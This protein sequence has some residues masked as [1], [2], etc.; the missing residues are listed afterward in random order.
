MSTESA[1]IYSLHDARK[2]VSYRT[3]RVHRLAPALTTPVFLPLGLRDATSCAP[4]ANSLLTG[5]TQS[6]SVNL[7]TASYRQCM[8]S[9]NV[10]APQCSHFFLLF[11]S[12][13]TVKQNILGTR[14]HSNQAFESEHW[15]N[16]LPRD[17]QASRWY[18]IATALLEGCANNHHSCLFNSLLDSLLLIIHFRNNSNGVRNNHCVATISLAAFPLLVMTRTICDE[19]RVRDIAQ[20]SSS[21]PRLQE[22]NKTWRIVKFLP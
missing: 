17:A 12:Q 3:H 19:F 18:C 8:Q 1:A 4:T 10:V 2:I 21:V 7:H 6:M 15:S 5:Q 20:A 13:I 9:R 22:T 16:I 14:H 11:N